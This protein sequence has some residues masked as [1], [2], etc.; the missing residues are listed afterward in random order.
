MKLKIYNMAVNKHIGITVR[1]HRFHDGSVGVKKLLS[2]AYLLWLNFAFY[3]LGCRFLGKKPEAEIY[4]EKPLQTKLSETENYCRDHVCVDDY[5]DEVSSYDIVSFDIFDT[6][7]IRPVAI[8]TDVFHM[9]GK[10]LGIADF[11]SIRSWAE[12]DARMKHHMKTGNMEV[13][14]QE[15]WDNLSQDVGLDAAS[16]MALE[17]QIEEAICFANPFM[18]QVWDELIERGQHIVITSDM[19]L[20]KECIENIL[21]KNGYTGFAKLYL[22]NEYQKSKADGKLYKELL[23]DYPDKRIIHIGDNVH[24]DVEMAKKAGLATMHYQNINKNMLLYRPYDMS[25]LIGSAYRGIVSTYLYNGL[26][27]Y[28]ME[29][30]YGFIYGGLFVL[31]YCNFIHDYVTKNDIDKILFLSRDGDILMQ[32]YRELYPDDELAYAYWSRKAATKMEAYFDKHDFFRRFI[33]HKLNQD[34]TIRDILKSMELEFLIDELPDWECIYTEKALKDESDSKELA[35]RQLEQDDNITNKSKVKEKIE[36]DFS[37]ELLAKKR[38]K[39]FINLRPDDELTNKNGYLLRQFIEAK[40][41]KVLAHYSDQMEATKRYYQ[42][43]IGDCHKIAAVDIGWAGSG[44]MVLRHLIRHEWQ[45]DCDLVGIIAGTNTIHNSEP[46]AS[47]VFLQSGELVSYLYSQ[48][49][50]R[51]LL[52]KHDPN[53]DYN[54]Y[55]EL[56]LSSPTPQFVGFYTGNQV[57]ASDAEGTDAGGV[58]YAADIDVTLRFGKYDANLDGICDVQQGIRDFV[59]EY[60]TRFKEFPYMERISGRDAYAPMLVAASHD[61]KYLKAIAKKFALKINVD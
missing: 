54:V 4:E 32:V 43:L 6:L 44:A 57:Y 50:N 9:I 26:N 35:I 41:D 53:R 58:Q 16:G 31:G 46:D 20:P 45:M 39:N 22:S 3:C 56:L 24:S 27:K 61:E 1:Y 29:Y 49:H 34:Y 55:W 19:Y 47:E 2:W 7:I 59:N 40:W 52:K 51:D 28:S 11:S 60:H 12:Y 48:S 14:L 37:E 23:A 42:N 38:K 10:E 8:P 18:K 33:Y 30:E 36:R 17:Q 13:D 15:I 21:Q 5:L 25:A